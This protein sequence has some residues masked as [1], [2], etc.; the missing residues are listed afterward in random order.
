MTTPIAIVDIET[1]GPNLDQGDRIIQIA[2]LIIEE[3][4][5]TK[6]YDMLINPNMPIPSHI[7]KLTG[8]SNEQVQ[9]A[10]HLSQVIDLWH[11]RL[12][13]CIFVAHNINFDLRFLKQCFHHFGLD[14]N[15]PALDTVKLAKIFMPQA[16]GFNLTDL[17]QEMNLFFDQAHQA[18]ADAK[19]TAYLLD[20][21]AQLIIQ[22][23][24]K[25]L[26]YLRPYL[27]HLPN[28]EVM[29]LDQTK[30]F[31][32]F[33][34][35][36]LGLT[37]AT[38]L[39]AN[40]E[41]GQSLSRVMMSFGEYAQACFH[42]EPYLIME[43]KHLPIPDEAI[44]ASVKAGLNQRKQI[45]LLVENLEQ[46]DYFYHALKTINEG[47]FGAIYK[48][49]ENFLYAVNLYRLVN[50]QDLERLNQQELIVM[51]ALIYWLSNQESGDLSDLH[52]EIASSPVVRQIREES[53]Y[54]ENKSLAMNMIKTVSRYP[55]IIM[56]YYDWMKLVTQSIYQ[57]LGLDKCQLYISNIESWIQVARHQEQAS[58]PLSSYFTQIVNLSDRIKSLNQVG[59]AEQI[60]LLG[61]KKTVFQ[62]IDL[63]E[64]Y[65]L[66]EADQDTLGSL[67]RTYYFANQD[68]IAKNIQILL[69]QLYLQSQQAKKQLVPS[70]TDLAPKLAF[71]LSNLLER[72]SQTVQLYIQKTGGKEFLVL[73]GD[74]IQ[75]QAYHLVLRKR[76]LQ[77]LDF[78]NYLSNQACLA[79][80][81]G[82]YRYHQK[83]GNDSWLNQ[84]NFVYENYELKLPIQNTIQ[85]PVLY[86]DEL[87]KQRPRDKYVQNFVNFLLDSQTSLANKMIVIASS[88]EQIQ[89][90]YPQVLNQDLISHNY[91]VLAQGYKG[92]LRKVC[93]HF[94]QAQKAILL[95][96]WRD[97]MANDWQEI[98]PSVQVHLLK[99]P[100]L[101]LESAG[102]RAIQD[103][104]GQE[105]DIFKDQ[106]LPQMIQ[107]LKEILVAVANN[108]HDNEMFIYDDRLFTQAYSS[109][110]HES[111]GPE[112]SFE[113]FDSFA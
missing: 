95:I 50:R 7:S 29:I 59:H 78:S 3:G 25:S 111:L 47:D 51:A 61:L 112:F 85:V 42:N 12:K 68:K 28:D 5:V 91:V 87:E 106:L 19:I 92:S 58:I 38:S 44:V 113:Y 102:M 53:S 11:Y 14:F 18:L 63:L 60:L 1:T 57:D 81:K 20:W 74:I 75:S 98:S 67:P 88:Q 33:N 10:P 84:A 8:I 16:I 43:N 45:I 4:Q 26:D 30:Q 76:S 89:A 22:A 72:C 101:S 24:A 96:T 35:E 40:E 55:L 46:A 105:T 2:A 9:K 37:L 56:R 31:L 93:R 34:K 65:I 54:Q 109:I 83:V 27:E 66:K 97:F 17:S 15:P 86:T 82:N 69:Q 23:E 100:F 48:N 79:F 90:T 99:L 13:D 110:I 108:L 77:I 52:S 64:P 80:S 32:I 107:T 6:E 71:D 21:I 103:Y 39:Q 62:L 70:L 94:K 49:Q 41:V 104:Y 36:K 73:Q